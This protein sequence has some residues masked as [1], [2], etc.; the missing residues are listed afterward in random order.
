VLLPPPGDAVL[1]E[2]ATQALGL[3]DVNDDAGVIQELVGPR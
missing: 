1:P 3:P 2:T